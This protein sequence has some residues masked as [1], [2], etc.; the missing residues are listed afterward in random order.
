ML[1]G[2]DGGRSL[3]PDRDRDLARYRGVFYTPD[4]VVTEVLRQVMPTRP[5]ELA[6]AAFCDPACGDG[7]FLL[8]VADHLLSW[9][10]KP[11][12]LSALGRMAGYDIDEDALSACRANL[13]NLLSRR[14]PGASV[15]WNLVRRDGTE[16]AEFAADRGRFT[17]VV[18]N[19]PFV[20]VQ[21]LTPDM[22]T[23]LA[24]QWTVTAGNTDLYLVF[25]EL[26]LDLL[27]DG[28]TMAY[29]APSGWMKQGAGRDLRR[30]L[31]SGHRV[32]KLIDY[33]DR[34]LFDDAT[35]Y[36]AVAVVEKGGEPRDVPAVRRVEGGWEHGV[37]RVRPDRPYD[38]WWVMTP[39]EWERMDALV[40]RGPRLCDVAQVRVGI[41]THADDVFI[42]EVRERSGDMVLADAVEE[43]V[44]IEAGA[45]RPV[46]KASALVDG[47]D[48]TER[49]VIFPYDD[50]GTLLPED[51]FRERWPRAYDWLSRHRDALMERDRGAFD[52]SAWYAFG[53]ATALVDGFGPK[54]VTPAISLRPNF[55]SVRNEDATF[56]SGYCVKTGPG[57]DRD[58]LLRELNSEDME[59]YISKV[60]RPYRSGYMSYSKTYIQNFPVPAGLA[61]PENGAPSRQLALL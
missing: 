8:A 31:A 37:A 4:T 7:A 43:T 15:D 59:F 51:L 32:S 28:G 30:L 29:I 56:Y 27:R 5:S 50:D 24:E 57:V 40:A 9:L 53:R 21:R 19:P 47:D 54:L 16:R 25:F 22:R 3:S 52:E 61:R 48:A 39:A 49:V 38:P 2:L 35:T 36:C 23:R 41:Q 1:P 34:Q 42:M 11:I 60:S 20:R 44:E 10:A 45:C 13:S 26:G 33:G 14:C 6:D 46:V 12:A 55:Q 58:A 17:H 18:G